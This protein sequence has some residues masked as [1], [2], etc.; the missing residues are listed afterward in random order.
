M[1]VLCHVHMRRSLKA[2]VGEIGDSVDTELHIGRAIC[3]AVTADEKTG[4]R[5]TT[6]QNPAVV[7]LHRERLWL[8]EALDQVGQLHQS[9]CTAPAGAIRSIVAKEWLGKW[10]HFNACG[11]DAA[12]RRSGQCPHLDGPSASPS[13]RRARG[14]RGF[15]N[16][17]S[18]GWIRRWRW[19]RSGS[20]LRSSLVIAA[21]AARDE[22]HCTGQCANHPNLRELKPQRNLLFTFITVGALQTDRG[23]QAPPHC[24]P[25]S[26]GHEHNRDLQQ[27]H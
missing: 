5:K 23:K 13:D 9:I 14:H 27:I 26:Y 11:P 17:R 22:Q 20:W 21:T 1:R 19:C 10:A 7:D 2:G 15:P 3:L 8:L 12:I 16:I 6:D 18:R 24:S 25:R 4:R